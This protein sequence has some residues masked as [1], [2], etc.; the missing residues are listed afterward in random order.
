MTLKEEKSMFGQNKIVIDK[1]TE[2]DN[3]NDYINLV[4]DIISFI[5]YLNATENEKQFYIDTSKG[6]KPEHLVKL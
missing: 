5:S 1:I 2:S 4:Y 6:L 3:V